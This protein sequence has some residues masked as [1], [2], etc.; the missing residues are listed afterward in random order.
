MSRTL[1]HNGL[2]P[3]RKFNLGTFGPGA[4]GDEA[5]FMAQDAA[6]NDNPLGR[7]IAAAARV[8]DQRNADMLAGKPTRM[9]GG[10][11]PDMAWDGFFGALQ[12]KG[13]QAEKHGLRFKTELAGHGPGEGIGQ[14][15]SRN[16]QGLTEHPLAGLGR[17]P[18]IEGLQGAAQRINTNAADVIQQRRAP[19]APQGQKYDALFGDPRVQQ[20]ANSHYAALQ[21]ANKRRY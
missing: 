8:Q 15:A 20:Q 9:L 21:A 5:G 19:I 4:S 11:A 7:N 12:Q 1:V 16:A 14:L 10:P 2:K 13:E 3:G 6:Q 17:A 18:S